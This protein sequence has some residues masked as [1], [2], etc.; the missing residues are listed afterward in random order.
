[1]PIWIGP[2]SSSQRF[3]TPGLGYRAPLLNGEQGT[4]QTIALMR[5]LVNDALNDSSF[6]RKAIEIV[7]AVPQFD[8]MGEV[9]ALYNWVK[10]NIRYTKDPTTKEKLYPPQELLKIRA[11]D[12]D[13]ISM[14]LAAF[15]L[16]VGY[17]ARWITVSANP[18]APEEFSHI[19]PEAEVP[20]GSRNWIALDAARLDSE[21]GVEPP[22][23]YRKRAW[24]VADDSYE[25]LSGNKRKRQFLSG[26]GLG[27]DGGDGG[28][29]IDWGSILQTAVKD[30][31][32]IYAVSTGQP[33]SPYGI[34]PTGNPYASFMTPM[35]PGYGI[36]PAGYMA[37]A[38]SAA[39][40]FSLTGSS[41]LPFLLLGG[42]AL[43]LLMK[44]R[45]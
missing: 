3:S 12:C 14:L 44:A 15:L 33:R 26:W 27:Q 35:T 6:V 28:G 13:D 36:P 2:Q 18:A 16:A 1:M 38:P 43:M 8:E 9:H 32:Q 41:M 20:A 40:A 31:P 11:G 25:D 45:S 5:K 42:L 24:S 23:W 21:F 4:A 19:Y 39:G 7:R 29:G 37:P 22:M 17:P 34:S 10:R 30:I